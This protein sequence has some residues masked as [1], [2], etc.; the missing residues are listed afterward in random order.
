MSALSVS[1][2]R[3]HLK[4]WASLEEQTEGPGEMGAVHPAK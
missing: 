3:G 1:G 2:G 4:A